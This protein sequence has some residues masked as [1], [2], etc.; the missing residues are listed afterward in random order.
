[1][2]AMDTSKDKIMLDRVE[3]QGMWPWMPWQK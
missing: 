1:L 3:A 2:A